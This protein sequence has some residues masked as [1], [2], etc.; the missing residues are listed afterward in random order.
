[1]EYRESRAT[2]TGFV[3]SGEV[4]Q[5]ALQLE[6]VPHRPVAPASL[7]RDDDPSA[8]LIELHR[9]VALNGLAATFEARC[10]AEPELSKGQRV[11]F[12][13]WWSPDQL[14]LAKETSA[15]WRKASFV[16]RDALAHGEDGTTETIPGGWDHEHCR[17]C[18]SSIDSASP[19]AYVLENDWL[20][21]ACHRTYIEEGLGASLG[22]M[23]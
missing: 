21:D 8:T 22:D 2:I 15:P 6:A 10:T 12:R 7:C 3:R 14:R 13:R 19:D 11:V 4:L 18:W 16:S 20:C 5:V 17:L 9:L 1:M 23:A